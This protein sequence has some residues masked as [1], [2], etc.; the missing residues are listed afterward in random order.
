MGEVETEP[1]EPTSHM[2]RAGGVAGLAA[3]AIAGFGIAA[4]SRLWS[5][6]PHA[7]TPHA[8][9]AVGGVAGTRR[10]LPKGRPVVRVAP[11]RRQIPIAV[12]VVTQSEYGARV[13]YV[14]ASWSRAPSGGRLHY[15]WDFG[16]G[17]SSS[18]PVTS[19]TYVTPGDYEVTLVV[20]DGDGSGFDVYTAPTVSV[21][22]GWSDPEVSEDHWFFDE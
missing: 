14:D 5:E 4:A 13:V 7:Q 9:V 15:T 8:R 22:A 1:V 18:E 19:H 3:L 20:T 16:D 17:A 11:T 6:P 2:P 21:V 12:G 10:L